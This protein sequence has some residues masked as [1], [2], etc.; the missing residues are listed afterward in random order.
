[1]QDQQIIS[2]HQFAFSLT[3]S[4]DNKTFINYIRQAI[5]Y[6]AIMTSSVFDRM[7]LGH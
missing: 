2:N 5:S 6:G 4:A 1:M 3:F 7:Y